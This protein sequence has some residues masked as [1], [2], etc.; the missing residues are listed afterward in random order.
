MDNQVSETR[1]HYRPIEPLGPANYD[2][3]ISYNEADQIWVRDE[4]LPRLV[5]AGLGVAVDYRDFI[6][7]LSRLENIERAIEQSRRTIVVLTP[8]WLASDWNAFESLLL[9]AVDPAARRRKLLPVLLKP[10]EELP[11]RIATLESV[12]LT[13]ERYVTRQLDRL[14][15]DIEDVIPVPPPWQAPDEGLRNLK[16][17]QRWLRRYRRELTWSAAGILSLWLVIFLYF[18]LPPFQPRQVWIAEPLEAPHALTLHN[19]GTT[20]IVGGANIEE[21]CTHLHKGLWYRPLQQNSTWQESDVDSTLLCIENWNPAPALSDFVALASWPTDPNTIYALTS[22]SGLLVSADG[23]AHFDRHPA[24]AKLPPLE[25]GDQNIL[26]EVSGIESPIFWLARASG[27]LWVYRN[28]QWSRL[29]GQTE[30]GCAGLP[31][32]AVASLLV[33]AEVV[34]IGSNQRGLWVSDDGGHTC[35]QVF[36]DIGRYEFRGLWDVSSEDPA[37]PA[38]YLALVHNWK[39]EPRGQEDSWQL[40]DLCPRAA[41]CSPT[42]WQA[43]S[44]PVWQDPTLLKPPV[45]DVLVQ[46]T[47]TGDYEWYL[48]TEAGQIW[49]GDLRGS[50]PQRLP[51]LNRCYNITA[52]PC[53]AHFAPA[54]SD[55]YPFL[56]AAGRVYD[57]RLGAWWRRLWP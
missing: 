50:P 37:T 8:A 11:P 28:E 15:R 26:L 43:E 41:L 33:R 56:L 25:T 44:T 27:G 12:D 18:Q 19:T 52:F 23:G 48:V 21:G 2:V 3:F 13:T 51:G 34:L 4:L 16:N 35:R 6:V 22:H 46:L 49:R 7:G 38:R 14:V 54:G 29:D 5:E 47:G 32:L 39:V 57:Y 30:A 24:T 53:E 40:L 36:D 1:G 17:W 10:C 45:D 42:A 9:S 20:L 55:Q 31:T